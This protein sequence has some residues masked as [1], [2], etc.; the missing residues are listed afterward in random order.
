MKHIPIR[1]RTNIRSLLNA[2]VVSKST[3]H[4]QIKEGSIRAHSNAVKPYLSDD[5]KKASLEFCLS[6]VDYGTISA[7][8]SFINMH[9][10]IHINEK[11]FYMSKTSQKYYFHL[12]ETEPYRTY[13]SKRFIPKIMFL[14]VVARP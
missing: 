5:N 6:M 9:N 2:L 12:D 4:G 11:W 3:V 8:P 10:R 7:K 14:A 13:K 1:R